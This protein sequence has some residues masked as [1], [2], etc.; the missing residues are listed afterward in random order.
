MINYP[1]PPS[2][3]LACREPLYVFRSFAFSEEEIQQ[4][5]DIGERVLRLSPAATGFSS[6]CYDK[7]IRNSQVSWLPLNNDTQW[8]YDRIGGIVTELNGQFFQFDMYGFAEEIQYTVYHGNENINEASHYTWHMDK[9][10]AAMCPRKL[11][12]SIQLSD[13]SEYD[14]G[15]LELFTESSPTILKKQQGMLYTFPSYV[16]HRVTPVTAGIRRTLVVWLTGPK[17]K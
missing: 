4:I 17:F 3:D 15:N 2:P 16:V 7:T 14:G 10:N 1:L 6:A 12:V 11:T 8:I 5:V 9:G 13:P